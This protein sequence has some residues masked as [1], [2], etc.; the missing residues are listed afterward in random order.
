[1]SKVTIKKTK[2]QHQQWEKI[3]ESNI[4][5]KGLV[6]RKYKELLQL[7]DRKDNLIKKWPKD[8]IKILLQRHMNG[9]K[10]IKK[11]LNA[12][13]HQGSASKPQ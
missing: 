11:M 7:N 1:M 12:L 13:C 5:N 3:F 6:F 10:H 8:L 2:G 4:L 9:N